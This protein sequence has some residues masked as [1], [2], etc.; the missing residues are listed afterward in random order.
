MPLFRVLTLAT[1]SLVLLAG[2]GVVDVSEAAAPSSTRQK[3]DAESQKSKVQSRLSTLQKSLKANEA[4]SE[5]TARA[6]K[7]ADQAIS[8]VNRKLRDLNAKKEKARTRLK[9]LEDDR[10]NVDGRRAQASQHVRTI[11][12][13]QYLNLKQPAWQRFLEGA[14]PS[15]VVRERASLR[16]LAREETRALSLLDNR[17]KEIDRLTRAAQDEQKNLDRIARE[18]QESRQELVREKSVREKTL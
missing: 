18:E 8:R 15:E 2:P 1:L 7:E 14:N 17:Q 12:R 11:A 4:K 6:L 3:A 13:A 10:K 5:E 16:Y 9:D